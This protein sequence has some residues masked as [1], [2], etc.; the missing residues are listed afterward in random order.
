MSDES[1]ELVLTPERATP[2]EYGL[3]TLAL[4]SEVSQAVAN[5]WSSVTI[6]TAR[7]VMQ[8]RI[9]DEFKE[10]VKHYDDPN[11][12]SRGTEPED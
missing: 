7:H 4:I 2:V 3:A 8:T 9:D 10:I 1:E 6:V 11:I 12:G 5:F